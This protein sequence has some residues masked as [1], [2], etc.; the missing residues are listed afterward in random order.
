MINCNDILLYYRKNEEKKNQSRFFFYLS[1][2]PK[3]KREKSYEIEINY[4]SNKKLLKNNRKIVSN[5][6]NN[7]LTNK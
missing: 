6:N 7:I 3:T 1:F 4:S 2:L 5:F